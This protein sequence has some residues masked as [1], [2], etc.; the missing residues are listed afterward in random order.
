MEPDELAVTLTSPLRPRTSQKTLA[1]GLARLTRLTIKLIKPA[2]AVSIAL[3]PDN[4]PTTATASDRVAIEL[5][6][7]QNN[8][9]EGPCLHAL[10]G[11]S[12]RVTLLATDERFPISRSPPQ[13]NES[14]ACSRP[15]SSPTAAR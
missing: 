9:D 8:E 10:D 5:D 15:Q 11:R 4:H 6:L 2:T 13:I 12:V 1:D 3:L 14:R 7:D